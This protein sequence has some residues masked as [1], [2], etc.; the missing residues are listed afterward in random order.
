METLQM[1]RML[2]IAGTGRN[3]GKTT[4][5][6]KIIRKFQFRPII[7]I[8][9]TPHF[10]KNIQS[11][12]VLIDRPDLYIAEEANAT[13]LKDSSLMLAA[14]AQQSFFVMATDE[15]LRIA[16]DEICKIVPVNSL[17]ICESGG[18]RHHL[19]PGIFLMMKGIPSENLKSDAEILINLAD[20]LIIF[21]G[22]GINFDFEGIEITDNQWTLKQA[23]MIPF[24]KAVETAKSFVITPA[25]GRKNLFNAL[26][27]I[28]AEDVYSDISMPP[29]NKS[30]MDGY[31]C[32]KSD[33]ENQLIVIEEIAA[34]T[35]PTKI[36]GE[37][38]CSRIMTGA[39][40][41][42]GAD[43]VVMKEDIEEISPGIVQCIRDSS[44]SNICYL[45]EDVKAGDQVLQKGAVILPSHIAILASVGC[46][47]PLVYKSPSVA[48]I[49]TGN[50]LVEPGEKP[51]ISKIRNSNS[52]QLGAQ[53]QQ[54]GIMPDYLGIVADIEES[55]KSLLALA[56]EKYDLTI[57]SGG[58]SVG[59]FDFVPKILKSLNVNI[60]VHGMDVKPGKHL[61][62]GERQ[63]HFVFGM[64][65]NP[66]SSFVQFEVLVK[67][68]L[69]T[70]MGRTETNPLL[71]L[72]LAEDFERNKGDQ[73]LFVPVSFTESGA[74]LPL[75]Y[76]GSAHIHAYVG[77]HGIM[78]VP[79]G[80]SIIKKGEIACVRPL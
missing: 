80:T 1:P 5:A 34:G 35:I 4:L 50:E 21:D 43:I 3:T 63:N 78:E 16:I 22:K 15:N 23:K 26:N 79:K 73:L 31:A 47:Q 44:K 59:D 30:A 32:R 75:E 13:T 53:V 36:V 17:F 49:S 19:V 8:K 68:F 7:A 71:Y 66:V 67:P 38:Q 6:C 10:H 40:V 62:F 57:I 69:Q 76:H 52:Y 58:V 39:M 65:G 42:E 20:Q 61:L 9:I 64:P 56:I 54:L 25:T 77:A 51:G 28:L 24:E 74:I 11:G 70:L 2:L 12:K 29:F 41:P 27:S 72:P 60:R 45:G 33:L 14:G 55:L 46:V 37:N 18:L 48:I